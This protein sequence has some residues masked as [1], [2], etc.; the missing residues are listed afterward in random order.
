MQSYRD[1]GA[2]GS[3][4]Q[5]ANPFAGRGEEELGKYKSRY[6]ESMNPFTKFQSREATRAVQ[7]LNPVEGAVLTLTRHILG[8]RRARLT[9]IVYIAALH[10]LVM[11]TTYESMATPKVA[12]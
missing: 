1:D 7:A 12:R 2:S 3:G 10:V 11:F 5:S 9:F 4:I 6:E 8:N